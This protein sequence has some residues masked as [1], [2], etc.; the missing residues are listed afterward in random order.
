[1]KDKTG[2]IIYVG[3]AKI[4]T[5]RVHSYF[6]GAHDYKTTK[7]VS[8]IADFETIITKTE[9]EALILE[10]NLIKKHRPRYNIMFMDDA[11]YP[12]LKLSKED[13][14]TLVVARDRK[15]AKNADYFGP[16]TDAG[17][18]RATAELLNDIYPLRKCKTMPKK[19]CLYYHLGQC[20]GPCEFTLEAGIYEQMRK[21][22]V[23]V[24]KGDTQSLKVDL[25]T[26]MEAASMAMKYELASKY[27]DQLNALDHISDKQQVQFATKINFDV[28]NYAYYQGFIAIVG[29]FVRDGRL[30]EKQMNTSPCAEEPNDALTSFIAQY[31][32]NQPLVKEVY[33]PDDIDPE[34][35][36]EVL[37]TSVK[38]AQRGQR[39]QL[40]DLAGHNAQNALMD[41]FEL[42]RRDQDNTELALTQLRDLLHIDSVE[43]IELF[44]NSHISG[45]FAVAACVVYEEGKPN[46][47]LYRRYRLHQGNNDVASMQEVMYRRYFRMMKE[48]QVLPSLII[49]DGGS[50]QMNAAQEIISALQ[51][52]IAIAGLVKDNHHQTATLL[53]LDGEPIDIIKESALFSLLAQMQDE[54]HRFAISYHRLLRSKAQTKSIL[55]EV[56]GLGEVRK[57]KLLRHF[58]SLKMIRQ[59]SLDELSSIVPLDVA[60]TIQTMLNL[61]KKEIDDDA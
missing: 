21:D 9:K 48:K 49:V 32:Q 22:V 5:N 58:G 45:S 54:V 4:L 20:L 14:P 7:M 1:M 29:F 13:Y 43:R 55:D 15:H 31:Y 47:N 50:L 40:V 11:S 25:R 16:Y 51:L 33:V 61:E 8:L 23:R 56:D 6:R 28:F 30:L 59:A 35:L 46:K 41:K 17:S 10:I 53:G 12:Y 60:E 36:S 26:K 39:R 34:L 38:H 42:L 2:K 19:V 18:A 52:N 24:L 57:K 27:R 3:K 44:D 37:A